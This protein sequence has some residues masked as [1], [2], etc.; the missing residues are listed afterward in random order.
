MSLK[1]T[2]RRITY[3]IKSPNAVPEITFRLRSPFFSKCP[4]Y[5]I[6]F[7][8]TGRTWLKAQIGRYLQ[9]KNQLHQINIM[10]TPKLSTTAGLHPTLFTHDRSPIYGVHYKKLKKTRQNYKNSKVIF[11]VREPKDV[12][13]SYYFQV[14]K[15]YI[16]YNGTLSEFIRSDLYPL[17]KMLTFYNLWKKNK[18]VPL[19]Y[20]LVKY[21]EMH[22]DPE[23]VLEKVLKFM[24]ENEIDYEI[25]REAIKYTQ[26][27]NLQKLEKT[28]TIFDNTLKI[29]KKK[30]NSLHMRK[31]KIGGYTEYLSKEDLTFIDEIINQIG[32]SYY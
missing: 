3:A 13:V 8:K 26:F 27:E 16:R 19:D 4:V 31:G 17:Q 29:D 9:Q 32:C 25:M 10:D 11:M 30:T 22:S 1:Q 14:T 21:E 18:S 7:P 15:R 24:G 20:L 5:I 12:I 6:S 2:I 23:R 28:S